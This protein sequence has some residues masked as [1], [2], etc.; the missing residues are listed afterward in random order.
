VAVT[1][2]TD[3]IFGD[4]FDYLLSKVVPST[5]AV[6]FFGGEFI[7]EPINEKEFEFLSGT[8]SPTGSTEFVVQVDTTPE[9][10]AHAT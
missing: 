6:E 9:V 7:V 4:F 10:D 1:P 5:G 2:H 8:S 3:D